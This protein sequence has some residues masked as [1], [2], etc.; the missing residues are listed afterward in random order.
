MSDLLKRY[1]ETKKPKTSEARKI[2]A[3]V[4]DFFDRT[5]VWAKGFTTFEK[6]GN[7]TNFTDAA[8]NNFDKQQAEIV[9]PTNF[10]PTEQGINLHRWSV[11]N[12]YY[13]PGQPSK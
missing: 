12:S 13:K 6:K 9:L 4:T 2:P 5:L 8:L 1:E 7:T 3:L 11:V 10:I